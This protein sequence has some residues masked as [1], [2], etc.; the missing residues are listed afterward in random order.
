MSFMRKLKRLIH[1]GGVKL[2]LVQQKSLST[3]TDDPRI[4]VPAEEYDR[5]RKAKN[6]YQDKLDPVEY[7]TTKGKQK[8]PLNSLNVLKSASQAL[9]SLMFN[10][11][12]SIKVNDSKLQNLLDDIFKD[13]YF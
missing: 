10:E 3:I 11:R 13:N 2:G 1:K 7:W 6:Y 8:R 9:A 5:I 12:C 4:K